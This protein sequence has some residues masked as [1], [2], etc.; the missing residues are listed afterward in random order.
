MILFNKA[1]FL[2]KCVSL[3]K[4]KEELL[5]RDLYKEYLK[6]SNNSISKLLSCNP[7]IFSKLTNIICNC[8]HILLSKTIPWKI[9]L[10][11]SL[12]E[13]IF[14][15]Y[16]TK[17]NEDI[18]ENYGIHFNK[19]FYR[20]I[21]SK[22]YIPLEN[23]LYEHQKIL[24]F[25]IPRDNQAVQF[26]KKNRNILGPLQKLLEILSCPNFKPPCID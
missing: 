9:S 4:D 24:D 13:E 3:L 10:S 25:C 18:F 16:N 21:S 8:H 7:K 26:F 2:I 22:E 6:H 5:V 19:N 1:K 15:K 17:T 14:E 23:D 11:K 12:Q 20:I